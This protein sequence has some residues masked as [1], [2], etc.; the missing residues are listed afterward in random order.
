MKITTPAFLFFF[1]FLLIYWIFFFVWRIKL[2]GK[3]DSTLV[4]PQQKKEKQCL[5][6]FG[7][8]L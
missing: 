3:I 7:M 4:D 6:Q 2:L 1:F 5:L 8:S